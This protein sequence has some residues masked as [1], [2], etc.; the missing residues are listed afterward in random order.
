ME[1]AKDRTFY[2]VKEEDKRNNS[3]VRVRSKK[4]NNTTFVLHK[5]TRTRCEQEPEQEVVSGV[6]ERVWVKN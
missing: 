1:I 3:L 6:I 4:F 5:Y 2:V